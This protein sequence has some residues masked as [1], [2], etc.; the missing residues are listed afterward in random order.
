MPRLDGNSADW[1]CLE[2]SENPLIQAENFATLGHASCVILSVSTT[3]TSAEWA[4]SSLHEIS[5][6]C[7]FSS[8]WVYSFVVLSVAVVK[9]W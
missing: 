4:S 1:H 2:K 5:Q 7:I 3:V 9:V 6:F 8:L